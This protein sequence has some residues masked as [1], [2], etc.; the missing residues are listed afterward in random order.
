MRFALALSIAALYLAAS[1]S[2]ARASV[3]I[4][5]N[6]NSLEPNTSGYAC[7]PAHQCTVANT[8]LIP[9]VL[10]PGG[11]GSPVKGTVVSFQVKTGAQTAPLQFRVLRPAGGA[12]TGEGTSA[13]VTPPINQISPAYPVS[14][15]I[16]PGDLIGLNCCQGGHN[17]NL[18]A[19]SSVGNFASWGT[20]PYALL[21]DGETRAPDATQMGAVLVSAE[22]APDN[23]FSFGH[24]QR[25][26]KKGTAT[27]TLNLPNPGDLTASGNG[28]KAASAGRA[29]IS[30]SVTAGPTK[31]LIKAKGKK[32]KTLNA[33]GKVKLKVAVTYTPTLGDA[34][35]RSVKVKLIKKL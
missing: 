8:A 10:A 9:A 4:G 33:T 19:T 12:Y 23:S 7:N 1:T 24:V 13:P 34:H 28:V 17:N 5:A 30:K 21:G 18:T 35:T 26:K 2:P 15:P 27:L 22:V 11:L 31:L 25:S 3:T 6:L 20:S 14:L 29:V 16:Q 32:K